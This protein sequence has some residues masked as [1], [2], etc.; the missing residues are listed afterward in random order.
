MDRDQTHRKSILVPLSLPFFQTNAPQSPVKCFGSRKA[1]QL[2]VFPMGAL[3]HQHFLKS[4]LPSL[5]QREVFRANHR[6]T[7]RFSI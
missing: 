2:F 3:V 1:E 7:L 5:V 6:Q 4:F